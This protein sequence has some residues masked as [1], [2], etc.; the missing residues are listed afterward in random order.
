MPNNDQENQALF[1]ARYVLTSLGIETRFTARGDALRGE[2][3]LTLHAPLRNPITGEAI[4]HLAFSIES[5][6]SLRVDDPPPLRGTRADITGLVSMDRLIEHLGA[7]L[8]ERVSRVSGHCERLQRMGLDTSIDGE[9]VAG[10]LRVAMEPEGTATLEV[11]E[12][13]LVARYL[14][15]SYG[16]KSPL[17]LGELRFDLEMIEDRSD[18]EISLAEPVARALKQRPRRTPQPTREITLEAPVPRKGKA[19]KAP[20]VTSDQ[21][22]SL[23]ELAAHF[24]ASAFPKPGFSIGRRLLLEGRQ[25]R[26]IARHTK[27][28]HFDVVL[29]GQS[30]VLWQGELELDEMGSIEDWITEVLGGS[31]QVQAV[32]DDLISDAED[33]QPSMI[34]GLLPPVPHECWVMDVRIEE[35]DGVEV[36]YRGL[37]VG[38]MTFGAP[39]VLPKP[40]FEASYLPSANG[41]RMLIQV[42]EV[43]E[44]AVS[45]QRL[46][47]ER[48]PV[49]TPKESALVVFLANFVAESAAY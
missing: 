39:R 21:P 46:D 30:E 27:G 31:P 15:P 3:D 11:D 8:L 47:S 20:K 23:R 41:Y 32:D 9:R 35:D 45:Y 13:G 33:A 22:P 2:I 38:G 34:A 1:Q 7:T 28:N 14:V 40:A 29:R 10:I 12:H 19:P 18:L 5:D 6:G 44:S 25:V 26:F 24:G 43:S 17:P 49:G 36:R 4:S 48:A 16:D 42:L 37:N